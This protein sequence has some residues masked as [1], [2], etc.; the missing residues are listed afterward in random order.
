MSSEIRVVVYD[1]QAKAI[2]RAFSTPG[3]FL[4]RV[5]GDVGK[6][7][8]AS[9]KKYP[10]QRPTDYVRTGTLGRRW[11]Y[12]VRTTLYSAT[13]VL[14]NNTPY[15]PYV[16]SKAMQAQVHEG[17]GWRTDEDE[18]EAAK[19]YVPEMIYDEIE[20]IARQNGAS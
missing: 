9:I 1:Q 19:D 7:A 3:V 18:M 17:W 2:L 14:G 11:T 13:A 5:M 12:E 8:Q 20:R 10:P 6:Q 4:R 15:G 16:Q